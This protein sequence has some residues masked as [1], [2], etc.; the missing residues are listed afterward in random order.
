MLKKIICIVG[1]IASLLA[2][3]G[4]HRFGGF[5]NAMNGVDAPFYM[6]MLIAALVVVLMSEVY[7]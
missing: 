7:L 2:S 6:G 4:L 1:I 3:E 5:V